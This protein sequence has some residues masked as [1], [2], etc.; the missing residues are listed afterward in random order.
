MVGGALRNAFGRPFFDSY[1]EM[2]GT[3]EPLFERVFSGESISSSSAPLT[4]DRGN[5]PESLHFAFAYA[6]IWNDAGKVEGFF[7]SCTEVTGLVTA[8]DTLT[9]ERD[10]LVRLVDDTDT[11]ILALNS[12]YRVMALN[13]ANAVEFERVF[14]VRPKVGDKVLDLITDAASREEVRDAWSAGLAGEEF[15][16]VRQFGDPAHD[17]RSYEITFKTLRDD[18]GAIIGAYQFARDVTERIRNEARLAQA[19]EALI[20][21]QKLEAMGQLTGGVAHDFNNLLTPIIGS[22]DLLLRREIGGERERRLI[23][24]AYQS[25]ERAKVLVQ[26]LLAF[27]RRQPLQARPVDIGSLVQGMSDLIVSAVGPQ[28]SVT[29]DVDPAAPAAKADPNQLEMAILNLAI[30]AR[31]AMEGG[32]SLKVAVHGETV[33]A[34]HPSGLATGDYVLIKI[35]DTGVGMDEATLARAIEP[36]YSTKGIGKGTG[37]GLSMAHGLASQLGGA[38]TIASTPRI[39]TEIVFWLPVSEG[40]VAPE[41][42][43]PA[44]DTPPSPTMGLTVLLV[45]DEDYVRAATADMLSELA[46]D[47]REA[48]SAEE[49]LAAMDAGLRPDVLVTDHLMPGISGVELAYEV[50]ARSPETRILIISGFAEV[51]GLDPS[52][53]RLTKPFLHRDLAAAVADLQAG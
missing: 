29:L 5:G 48:A 22:L 51:D 40:M 39:G 12:D 10:F 41:G 16:I 8:R 44:P 30:N 4:L 35:A 32:G 37:L 25:A 15:T 46:F 26:R 2:Q 33:S 50:R 36:F 17:Q 6:P 19:Q 49:A 42:W 23:H 28:V 27:A 31:D 20:Q 45:E 13:R 7:I 53:P 1:P 24:G 43:S 52:L 11:F 34:G 3:L 14:G 21:S 9:S 38:L 18:A 47:V